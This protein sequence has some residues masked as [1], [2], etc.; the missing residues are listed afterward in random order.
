MTLL[1]I[2]LQGREAELDML[3][4]A[5]LLRE[6]GVNLLMLGARPMWAACCRWSSTAPQRR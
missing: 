5:V 1:L 3:M 2:N 6:I 4:V